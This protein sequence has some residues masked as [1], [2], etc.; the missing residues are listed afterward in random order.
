MYALKLYH[1]FFEPNAATDED[2]NAQHSICFVREGEVEFN[3]KKAESDTATYT[4]EPTSVKA[5]SS[6]AIVWRWEMEREDSPINLTKGDGVK[7]KLKMARTIRMFELYP[8]SKY[9][10]KLDSIIK[11]KGSTGL[12]SH[13]GSGM[14]CM[15]DGEFDIVSTIG[16]SF[17]NLKNG[18]AWYEEGA[19]P[20]VSTSPDG[21]ET[22]FLR[23]M[24]LPPEFDEYPDTALWI[25]GTKPCESDWKLYSQQLITL[26]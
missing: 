9:L 14:R 1:D 15:I 6:G 3:G 18:D 24:I 10:F 12:H 23:C 11:H 22:T 16:E 4:Q 7:S 25:E 8:K 17:Y 5:G 13:P 20:L 21:V 19:Y 2:I 26:L